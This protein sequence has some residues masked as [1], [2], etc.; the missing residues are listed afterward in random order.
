MDKHFDLEEWSNWMKRT[1]KPIIW[2][3]LFAL[4]GCAPPAGK[5][6]G[7][8]EQ[9]GYCKQ[10]RNRVFAV[11]YLPGTTKREIHEHGGGKMHTS[12]KVTVVNFYPSGTDTPGDRLS[13]CKN[14]EDGLRVAALGQL[15]YQVWINPQSEVILS[16]NSAEC[17]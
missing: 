4:F 6:T 1:A 17:R 15:C 7:K 11:E 16:D 9:V 14:L 5:Q 13:L 10:D 12:G 8:F 3:A 2:I